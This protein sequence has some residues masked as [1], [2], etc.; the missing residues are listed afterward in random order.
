M[1]DYSNRITIIATV[2]T[3]KCLKHE[4]KDKT[5]SMQKEI[6]KPVTHSV[7]VS[8]PQAPFP[9]P[10]PVKRRSWHLIS[11]T[12]INSLLKRKWSDKS[13]SKKEIGVTR[14]T[15]IQPPGGAQQV[16]ASFFGGELSRPSLE[17]HWNRM[18]CVRVCVCTLI[19]WHTHT[20]TPK[21]SFLLLFVNVFAEEPQ[22]EA[23]TAEKKKP[24]MSHQ[25]VI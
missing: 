21:M 6:L 20:H 1:L 15:W 24:G 3:P 13:N 18:T 14:S 16:S 2:K 11:F 12:A 22:T 7:E 10:V 23:D 9:P 8:H 25:S 4:N 17:S 19:H 5:V